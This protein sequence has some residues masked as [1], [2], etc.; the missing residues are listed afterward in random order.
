VVAAV[1]E[2]RFTRRKHDP[3]FPINAIRYSLAEARLTAANLDLVVYYEDAIEKFD[4]IAWSNAEVNPNQGHG[5]DETTI[6]WLR[7]GKFHPENRI[8]RILGIAPD[9][10][11]FVR[12]HDAHA[13]AAYFC[14]P[15]DEATIVTIDA[16]GEYETTSWSIGKGKSIRRLSATRFPDSLGLFYS[17]FTS[18]L[19]FEVLEGEYKVMGLS[20]Y[21]QPIHYKTIREMIDLKADGSVSVDQTFFRFHHQSGRLYSDRFSELFNDVGQTCGHKTRTPHPFQHDHVEIEQW[22]ADIAASVQ[23]CLEEAVAHIVRAAVRE[24]GIKNVYLAGGVALNGLAN[25]RLIHDEGLTIYVQPAAGDA[26]SAIGAAALGFHSDRTSARMK[27]LDTAYLGPA[28]SD[29]AITAA[30]EK[31]GLKAGAQKLDEKSKP[32]VAARH[33]ADG[34]IIGWFQGRAEWGPRSLGNRSIL[35]DPRSP[36]MKQIVNQRVKYREP[37][38]PF[39]PMVTAEDASK[40]FLL[41]PSNHRGSP[42]KFML[43]V[44]SVLPH[45]RSRIPATTHVDGSARVQTVEYSEN[46]LLYNLLKNF[47][48]LSEIP[49]PLNTYFNLRGEPI[50]NSPDDALKTFMYSGL[51]YFFIGDWLIRKEFQL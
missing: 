15:F 39:A 16:V 21:G 35:A 13:A 2:E 1:Q 37:F 51:D 28:Y 30:I 31:A 19:G 26:G 24:T 10:V 29:R 45:Q 41:G 42:E 36:E 8:S 6:D 25:A 46:P 20:A 47:Q 5:I 27:S 48:R 38:R 43:A 50:V 33:L 12:H 18:F 32:A 11:Q 44:H 9:K 7:N 34:K 23:K 4:R 22:S 3:S 49:I 40:Y 17:A 14:S